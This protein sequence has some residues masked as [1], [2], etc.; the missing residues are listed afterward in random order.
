MKRQI[1]HASRASWGGRWCLFATR[2]ADL[3]AAPVGT[4]ADAQPD[5]IQIGFEGSHAAVT[6]R[7]SVPY[8]FV[9][10]SW[11]FGPAQVTRS[12]QL[13]QTARDKLMRMSWVR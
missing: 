6:G 8:T 7:S 2:R 1:G 10:A 12:N 4:D 9:T 3:R 5:R 11:A 13:G